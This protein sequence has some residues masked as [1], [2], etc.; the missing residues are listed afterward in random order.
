MK[1]LI[2][3]ICLFFIT[4]LVF[5]QSFGSGFKS[6]KEAYESLD[7]LGKVLLEDCSKGFGMS[8]DSMI[9]VNDVYDTFKHESNNYN[10]KVVAVKYDS[11]K[12]KTQVVEY[13]KGTKSLDAPLFMVF[14]FGYG[15]MKKV[16]LQMYY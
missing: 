8:I 1:K 10:I 11:K 16:T 3:S 12:G 2:I 4:S 5:G 7:S 14:V 13:R 6:P 9:G 15:D